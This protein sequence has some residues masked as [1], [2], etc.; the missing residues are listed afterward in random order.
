MTWRTIVI[1]NRSKIDYKMNYM[2]VRKQDDVKRIFLDEIYMLIIESTAV[3]MTA[4]VLNELTKHKIQVV[5][6]DTERNP[7]AL[8][9]PLYGT[10]NCS[11][12][13]KQQM[14]WTQNAKD[15]VWTAIVK[16]KI[17][18]QRRLLV[19][20]DGCS[21]ALLQQYIDQ[22]EIADATNREGH[23]AKV[24]FHDLFGVNFSR[25]DDC[26]I[27]KALNYGYTIL[28]SAINREITNSGFLTQL[29]IHHDNQFNVF[30]LSC[31]LMEPLR[32]LVDACVLSLG[33]F[34]FNRDVKDALIELLETD[35]VIDG[36]SCVLTYAITQY[37]R[38]V[39]QALE[40]QEINRIRFIEYEI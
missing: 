17:D 8:L 14:Q 16:E 38:S 37:C 21:A 7:Y 13:L 19:K 5:F 1:R 20:K 28:L 25:D 10:H 24:Y 26:E 27:N 9:Q 30:N 12:K 3:S 31:D 40:E 33:E 22:I 34:T 36:K 32:I 11:K 6:C 39:F 15:L 2:I 29:G 18:K 4:V 35:V 23:A